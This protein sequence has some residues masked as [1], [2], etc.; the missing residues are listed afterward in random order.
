MLFYLTECAPLLG[1]NNKQKKTEKKKRK[2]SV[3]DNQIN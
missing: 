1:T 3:S 2:N